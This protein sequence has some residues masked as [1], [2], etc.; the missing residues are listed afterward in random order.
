MVMI[1][2]ASGIG[3]IVTVLQK[4]IY[5]VVLIGKEMII[6]VLIPDAVMIIVQIIPIGVMGVMVAII[7]QM[8]TA[9]GIVITIA[10]VI[11]LVRIS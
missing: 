11:S 8:E 10:M 9:I 3:R 6:T 1:I 2:S 4:Q 5:T 7:T